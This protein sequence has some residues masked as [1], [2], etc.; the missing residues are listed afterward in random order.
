MKSNFDLLIDDSRGIY[1]FSELVSHL[2]LNIEDWNIESLESELQR[3]DDNTTKGIIDEYDFDLWLDIRDTACSQ[4][5][6]GDIWCIDWD[7]RGIFAYISESRNYE[8]VYQWD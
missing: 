4:D 6:D 1:M 5:I 8:N 7:D 3:F 2:V